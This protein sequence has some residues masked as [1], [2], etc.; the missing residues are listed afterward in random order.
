MTSPTN[1]ATVNW[2]VLKH[3]V[4]ALPKQ[5]YSINKIEGNN[6]RPIQGQFGRVV[7]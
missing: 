7:D 3:V 1:T 5:M 6:A 2:S 4:E